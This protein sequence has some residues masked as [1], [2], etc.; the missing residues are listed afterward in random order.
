MFGGWNTTARDDF[1]ELQL[2]PLG[3]EAPIQHPDTTVPPAV[4]HANAQHAAHHILATL[5]LLQQMAVLAEVEDDDEW[6]DASY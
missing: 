1:Y 4:S 3:A 5:S 2:A 6:D